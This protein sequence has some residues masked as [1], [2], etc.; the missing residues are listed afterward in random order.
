MRRVAVTLALTALLAG[1][2]GHHHKQQ[3]AAPAVARLSAT[4]CHPKLKGID[5]AILTVPLDHKGRVRGSLKLRVALAGPA[6]APRGVAL[7]LTG[8]PGESGA[9]FIP[10]ILGKL[11]NAVKGYRVVMLDQRG[12]G[13]GAL[14]CPA[15]Q[16]A[17]GASDLAVPPLG[18]LRSCA[19]S[20]GPRRRFYTTADTLADLDSLRGALGV[21]RW[22]LDGVS[23]GTFVAERYALRYPDRVGRLVLDS[24]VPHDRIEPFQLETIHAVPRVLRAACRATHCGTDPVSDLAAVVRRYHNGPALLDS[25]VTLSIGDPDYQGVPGALAA[26]R[27]GDPARLERLMAGTRRGDRLPA[28]FLSV[29]LHDS[30]L[31]ADYPQPWGGPSVP[32]AARRAAIARAAARLTPAT[33]APFDKA[34]ATS[35]G[36]LITCENWPPLP[37]RPP[38]VP[39]ELPDVP[40]LLLAGD[41]DLS[42]PLAWAREEARRAPDGRLVV[43]PGAGHSVQLRAKDPIAR[44]SLV[45]FL[46]R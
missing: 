26:A 34:T 13:D 14:S 5:C 8:G 39:R 41:R 18:A 9:L 15:L 4:S 32:I 31:C 1:C 10:A 21:R 30:T 6:H 33:V 24:V 28:A 3:A 45:R 27:A 19:A 2:S 40:V 38:A 36:E 43:V 25:L 37:L 22:T 17:V 46:Q 7:F 44:R 35:N 20:I 12:T 23:Y 42:T 16:R 29:G 11:G